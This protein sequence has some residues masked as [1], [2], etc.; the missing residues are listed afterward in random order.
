[1]SINVLVVDSSNESRST[2]VE[3]LGTAGISSVTEASDFDSAITQSSQ[4]SYDAVLINWNASTQGDSSLIQELRENGTNSPIF[5]VSD[6]SESELAQQT[7]GSQVTEYI[8]TPLDAQWLQ[9]TLSSNLSST[10]S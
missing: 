5:L 1:M 3:F 4:G 8:T 2:L 6:E 9:E 7:H 10:T